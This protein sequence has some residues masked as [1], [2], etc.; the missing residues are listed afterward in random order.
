MVTCPL[1]RVCS[2]G[3]GNVFLLP[4]MSHAHLS[5]LKFFQ[6]SGF[7]FSVAIGWADGVGAVCE[8]LYHSKLVFLG[9]VAVELWILVCV[10]RFSVDWEN[11][12]RV[13]P[14]DVTV[15]HGDTAIFLNFPCELDCR[16][17]VVKVGREL[18]QDSILEN[19]HGAVHVATL[20]ARGRTERWKG[21]LR[22]ILHKE[23]GHYEAHRWPLGCTFCLLLKLPLE[24]EVSGGQAA[25]QKITDVI[26][27]ESGTLLKGRI[28]LKSASDDVD[29][30][31]SRH[32]DKQ[33]HH[34]IGYQAFIRLGDEA[35]SLSTSAAL[36]AIKY[37]VLPTRGE[38]MSA[39]KLAVSY[40]RKPLEATM[41]LLR[42]DSRRTSALCTLGR[43]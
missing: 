8:S 41:M 5:I 37:S 35:D 27:I 32:T 11:R 15:Q 17:L 6:V 38:R 7:L 42:E 3:C 19:S 25:F 39:M 31:L 21:S 29:T 36:L 1:S 22:K 23:V 16:V 26:Y 10:C 40:T 30:L 28:V 14:R 20:V 33:C 13:C 18:V 12:V 24:H 43:Q 34:I 4:G 2:S 9:L